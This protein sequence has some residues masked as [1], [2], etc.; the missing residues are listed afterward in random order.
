MH[1]TTHAH[2]KTSFYSTPPL[3]T[4]NPNKNILRHRGNIIPVWK[5]YPRVHRGSHQRLTEPGILFM[6]RAFAPCILQQLGGYGSFSTWRRTMAF[7]SIRTHQLLWPDPDQRQQWHRMNI[8]TFAFRGPP[9][10]FRKPWNK[11]CPTESHVIMCLKSLGRATSRNNRVAY[12]DRTI[13]T[14]YKDKKHC[15]GLNRP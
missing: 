13:S 12:F 15:D 8:P 10:F 3:A 4:G 9:R 5:R 2:A 6:E 7:K 1:R 14:K 11:F